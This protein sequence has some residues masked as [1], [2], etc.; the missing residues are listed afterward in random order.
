LALLPGRL[1]QQTL[2]RFG[3]PA[4]APSQV[5]VH[6]EALG[7][8]MDGV[9]QQRLAAL[10]EAA[11]DP[12]S[13]IAPRQPATGARL[14]A[15]PDALRYCTTERDG[16]TSKRVWR[17]LK[18]AAVYEGAPL[19]ADVPVPLAGETTPEEHPPLRCRVAAWATAQTPS[20]TLAPV[21]QAVRVTYVARTEPYARCGEFLWKELTE[22][23]VGTPVRDLAVVADGSSH[24]TQ[25]GDTHLR[26]P[27][28]QLT[29]ILDLPPAQQQLWALTKRVFG[30]GTPAGVRWVQEP[31]RL[32]ERG[33]VEQLCAHLTA[34]ATAHADVAAEVSTTAAF[35]TD[36]AAQVAYPTFLAQGYQIGSG[37][38]ESACKRFGT[39]R[40]KG[41]GM[42]W[43]V[44]GAQTVATLRMLLLSDRW[45]EVSA[46][47]R[48][49]A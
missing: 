5:R 49:A 39:D 33:Q 24:L 16:Q 43:T 36:R 35:F 6:G 41:A 28:R 19:T 37:L 2:G 31:L 14:Y 22:R 20:W 12:Q 9:E 44:P 38:A 32:L 15:A 45:S 21:D 4:V 46:H 29:R 3:W 26:L 42:R 7:A 47:C 30:E 13:V 18:A 1:G 48:R 17:E 40:M 27:D 23:G 10:Q 8:E 34:L 25:V 11:G